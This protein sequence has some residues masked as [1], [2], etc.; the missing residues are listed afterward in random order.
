[1]EASHTPLSSSRPAPTLIDVN[2]A[3]SQNPATANDPYKFS[4]GLTGVDQP[5]NYLFVNILVSIIVGLTLL[6]ICLRLMKGVVQNDR[7]LLTAITSPQCHNY[8]SKNRHGWWAWLKR[9]IIYSPLWSTRHN[10]EF[11]ISRAISV[12]T[13][14]TRMQLIIIMIYTAA[15]VAFCLAIPNQPETSKIAEF[16]GRCGA[17]AVFNIIFVVLFALRNNP[18]I[19]LLHVSYDTFNLFHRWI[20]RLVFVEALAHI[21]AWMY[22]TYRVEYASRSGWESINWVLGQSLSYRSGLASFIAF[23]F[24][25]LHSFGPLRHAFYET[26]LTL[27]RLTIIIAISGVYFHMAKH[28]LPQLPWGYLFI[29]FL[30][31]EPLIRTTRILYY[32]SSWRRRTWTKV[33]V[34]ALPGEVSRITFELPSSWP[35]NPGSFIHV[36]LPRITLWSSHPFSVAWWSDDE[37]PRLC[38]EKLPQSIRD[39]ETSRGPSTVSCIIRA[40]TGMTRSL[41]EKAGRSQTSSI[42]LWGAIEGPYGGY[43][44]L[45]SYGTVILFAAGVGITHQIS[46]VRHLLS[47]HNERTAA[48]QQILLVWSIQSTDMLECVKPWLDEISMMQNFRKVVRIR[49]HISKEPENPLVEECER[50]GLDVRY[51]RCEPQAIVDEEILSQIGAM[52]VTVCGPGGYSDTVR[53]AVR[54]RVQLRN[55]DFIEEAFSY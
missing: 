2:D 19:W 52:V 42:Q 7:R 43:H 25:I 40:R 1:M 11:R 33:I 32:N 37:H 31:A 54:R 28:A 13:L 49:L 20:A 6:A 16:R 23:S 38:S 18:F 14:P 27:H 47:G 51:A 35:A 45:D 55:I 10:R 21:F 50:Y 48:A 3:H 26:F 29:S 36:Y 9:H 41:Y 5:A 22:N 12:G 30:A 46:F 24:L 8:W 34:E 17:I 44:S 39:L 4:H 15:N 53:A